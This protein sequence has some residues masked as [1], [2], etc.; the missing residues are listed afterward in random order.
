MIS[1]K[2]NN[3]KLFIN[4]LTSSGSSEVGGYEIGD[5]VDSISVKIEEN[6]KT[7]FTL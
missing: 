4:T 3:K 7:A 6:N 5:Y 2:K 1:Y